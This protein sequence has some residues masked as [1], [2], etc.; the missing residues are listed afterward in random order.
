MRTWPSKLL[1]FAWFPELANQLRKLSDQAEQECWEYKKSHSDHEFPVLYNYIMRTFEKVHSEEKIFLSE[2]KEF[3]CF[4]TGLATANQEPLYALFEVNRHENSDLPWYFKNWCRRGQRDLNRFS[5]LPGLAHYF[6]DPSDL[7]LDFHKPFRLNTEHI[8]EENK[9]RFP[10]PYDSVES[11]QLKIMLDGA[12]NH[13][14]ERALRNY[15]V[16]IP[17]YYWGKV[18]LLLPLC[19]EVPRRADLALVVEKHNDFYRATTCLTLDM[20]YNNAR[21]LAKPDGDWLQP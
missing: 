19:L 9:D 17:Q 1:E 2:D 13:A 14:R 20:A 10:T 6:D 3:A 7:V 5:D 11:Y 15:K 21:Q 4:N 16:A 12:V 18:Q 8:I